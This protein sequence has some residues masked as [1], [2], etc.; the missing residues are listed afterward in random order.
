MTLGKKRAPSRRRQLRWAAAISLKT[1]ARA[2]AFDMQP[3]APMV[4]W[5]TNERCRLKDSWVF[6]GRACL[7]KCFF[8]TCRFSEDLDFT[9]TDASHLAAGFLQDIFAEIGAWIHATTGIDIP[10]DSKGFDVYEDARGSISC[11]GKTSYEQA[12][13]ARILANLPQ[14]RWLKASWAGQ[15]PEELQARGLCFNS[16]RLSKRP[17][18]PQGQVRRRR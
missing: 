4:R 9:L 13:G 17:V 16:R 15:P 1:M 18:R 7:K 10:A 14:R 5:R 11:W 3:L 2:V 12:T 8:E 6:K